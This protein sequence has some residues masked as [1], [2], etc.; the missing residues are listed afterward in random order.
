MI[1]DSAIYTDGK[2]KGSRAIEETRWAVR[3]AE[4]FAWIELFEPTGEEFDSI[5]RESGLHELA[6]EDAIT[7]HQRPKLERYDG[8][9]FL[10]LR[11]AR[12][13]DLPEVVEFGE[14]HAFVGTDFIITVRHGA[15]CP[16][17]SV[18]RR[19]ENDPGLLRMGPAAVLY[20]V[21]DLVVDGFDPVIRGLEKDVDE[22]E[23]QVF[24][25]G[26]DASQRIYGLSREVIQF[27]RAVQPLPRVLSLLSGEFGPEADPEVSRLLEDVYDHAVRTT[28][29]AEILRELLADI[30]NVNLTLVSVNLTRIG[31]EQNDQTKKISAWA[32]I[33]IVP[34]IISGVYGMN[35]RTMP[36]L[37]WV[38]GYPATLLLMVSISVAL[39]VG[40]KR[41]GWL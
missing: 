38:L 25:G 41:S 11:S 18:R 6:V 26:S 4:G 8:A 28:E 24:G 31:I 23:N 10:V 35:F 17:D 1:V 34:T 21:A 33:L 12:Y 7:A 22:I 3:E 15:A 5:T 40:F 37:N 27:R 29:Q 16:L 20:A 14:I 36:E 32:A 30:L 2:R 13:L 9:L 39:F 19:L